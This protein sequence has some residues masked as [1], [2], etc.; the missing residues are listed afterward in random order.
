MSAPGSD[1]P[2]ADRAE[3]EEPLDPPAVA[4]A[5]D[6]TPPPV[7]VPEADALEQQLAARPGEAGSPLRSVGDREADPADV[8]EQETDVPVDEDDLVD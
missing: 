2:E 8:L 1:V 4:L 5:G 7:D 3:Q 6:A